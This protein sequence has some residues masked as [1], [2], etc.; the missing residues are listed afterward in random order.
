[1]L[2]KFM[3]FYFFSLKINLFIICA[4]IILN[5]IYY[6][7]YCYLLLKVVKDNIDL[8]NFIIKF[9]TSFPYY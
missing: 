7:Y 8:V 5:L 9:I 6:W 4:I 1:M 2:S 3:K